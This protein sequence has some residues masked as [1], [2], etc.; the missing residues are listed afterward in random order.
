MNNL[1]DTVDRVEPVNAMPHMSAVPVN[2]ERV[3]AEAIVRHDA[4]A[5]SVTDMLQLAE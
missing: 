4:Q 1:I 2:I 3:A 5:R